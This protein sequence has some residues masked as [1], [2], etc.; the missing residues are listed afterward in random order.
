[1]S[2][3]TTQLSKELQ[4]LR[5]EVRSG[6]DEVRKWRNEIDTST[7]GIG[8]RGIWG[9][10]QKIDHNRD[11]ISENVHQI[12]IVK[13]EVNKVKGQVQKH[14]GFALGVGSIGGAAS[15]IIF[16]LIASAL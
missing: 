4:D 16:N 2:E 10:Q 6:F 1:M 9:Y 12:N 7:M 3:N 8:H 14:I 15:A 13:D 5:R 11:K